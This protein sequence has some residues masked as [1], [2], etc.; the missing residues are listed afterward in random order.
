[1]IFLIFSVF[2]AIRFGSISDLVVLY[3]IFK[4][5]TREKRVSITDLKILLIL[6]IRLL[7]QDLSRLV[8]EIKPVYYRL[9]DTSN[10][11]NK[12]IKARP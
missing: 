6:I 7:K 2:R 3:I 1:M 4:N 11:N 10:I 9:R 12:T 8:K 5:K